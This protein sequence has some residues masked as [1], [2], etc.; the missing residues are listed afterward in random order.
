MSIKYIILSLLACLALTGVS[1]PVQQQEQWDWYL[2]EVVNDVFVGRNYFEYY[3]MPSAADMEQQRA[4]GEVSYFLNSPA[5]LSLGKVRSMI[6]RLMA[7]YDDIRAVNAW[8]TTSTTCWREFRFENN[9]FRF[10]GN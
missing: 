7:S 1:Q 2:G 6:D 5:G 3:Y 10:T 8:Q 4:R 9:K